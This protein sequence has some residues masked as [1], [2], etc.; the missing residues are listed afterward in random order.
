MGLISLSS[1]LD[2][3]SKFEICNLV[4]RP[5]LRRNGDSDLLDLPRSHSSISAI[6][7]DEAFLRLLSGHISKD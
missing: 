2:M 7:L 1:M 4:L 3:M 5:A 6:R